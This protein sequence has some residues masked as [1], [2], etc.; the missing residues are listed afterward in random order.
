MSRVTSGSP[1][2]LVAQAS[3]ESCRV[4][5]PTRSSVVWSPS[6]WWSETVGGTRGASPPA[7]RPCHVDTGN[8]SKRKLPPFHQRSAPRSP[9]LAPFCTFDN[10]YHNGEIHWCLFSS[11]VRGAI[12][13]LGVPAAVVW[14][15][16]EGL[17]SKA[18]CC[19]PSQPADPCENGLDA[20]FVGWW[21][22]SPFSR[23]NMNTRRGFAWTTAPYAQC[24]SAFNLHR[25]LH[26]SAKHFSL[27]VHLLLAQPS[28]Q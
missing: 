28:T 19:E 21:T 14:W 22:K 26:G 12:F 4:L 15:Q 6:A 27:C 8:G 1:T 7:S 17:S 25:M 11:L 9:S 10:A 2:A 20:A 5:H 16:R 24:V 3:V 13:A 18:R 23:E